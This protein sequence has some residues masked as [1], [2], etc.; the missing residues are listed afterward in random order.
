M[1]RTVSF[2]T[3]SDISGASGH[4]IATKEMVKAFNNCEDVKL[5]FIGPKPRS[6]NAK[7]V[8]RNVDEIDYLFRK[9]G[10]GFLWHIFVQPILLLHLFTCR[11]SDLIVCRVGPSTFLPTYLP[12]VTDCSYVA[13]VRGCSRWE[14]GENGIIPRIYRFVLKKNV[15]CSNTVVVA[16]EKVVIEMEKLGLEIDDNVVVFP[17]AINPDHFETHPKAVARDNLEYSIGQGTY[18][19]GFVGSLKRWHTCEHL[20]LAA[21]ELKTS[22]DLH[23]LIVGSGP[24]EASLK[25]LAN[26]LSM[27]DCTTFT[28]FVEHDLVDE[29]MAACDVLY[30]VVTSGNPIK[31]YE[32]LAC[33]RPIITSPLPEFEF[34]KEENV[35][36][37]VDDVTVSSIKS[38]LKELYRRGDAERRG[39]GQRGRRY[40][41]RHHSWDELVEICLN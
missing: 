30:G 27:D 29:Y 32:Y 35:G 41:L 36:V 2:I 9:F 37:V 33:E 40:V 14:E 7:E 34:V 21:N 1:V 20:L 3:T 11:H 15:E 28:G 4:N 25:S 23:I 5:H 18:L 26:E 6:G 12:K 13:L 39:M 31:C 24:R 10:P 17:N 19:I 8:L 38:A 16:Y 22:I